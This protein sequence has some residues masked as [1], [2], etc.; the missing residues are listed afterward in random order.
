MKRFKENPVTSTF[1][2]VLFVF[3]FVILFV[4]TL[5]EL[6]EW[7][8]WA[9][10]GTSILLYNAKDKLIDIVTLGLSRIV[11]DLADR[12]SAKSSIGGGGVKD[13]KP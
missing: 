8:F 6:P 1:A 13:P 9:L 7:S 10:I 11:T 2:I 4:P 5:I 12:L 3:A